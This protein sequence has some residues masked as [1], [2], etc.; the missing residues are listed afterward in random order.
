MYGNLA[1]ERPSMTSRPHVSIIVCTYNR[2]ESLRLTLEAVDAQV[3][4]PDLAWELV[5]VDNNST[6]TT[7]RTVQAFVAGARIPV[8]SIFVSTQG[9]S[10]ARNAGLTQSRGDIVGFTDDDVR[11]A[12]DWVARI[13]TVM[14]DRNADIVGGRILPEW[15][16]PPPPWLA[17]RSSF[18]GALAIV[19]HSEAEQVLNPR[20][21]PSV[22]GA[23]MAFRREVF[24]KVG[25]FDVRRG[26][27]GRKLYRGEEVDLVE[28]A[29]AAGCRAVYDPS[30]VVW[31]RIGPDR[32]RRG[33]LARL[34]FER[35]EG[36][37]LVQTT[38]GH[39]T[40]LGVPLAR[41]RALVQR[42][43]QWLAA[44]VQRRPDTFERW[45]DCCAALGV[46]WGLGKR[47]FRN[48]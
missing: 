29:I 41:Y 31:H 40:L 30:I 28:R 25:M 19:T 36:E 37:A 27:V 33:Y 18:H 23:N 10:H 17:H 21:R 8:R 20:V 35:A 22:W 45:L 12:S 13:A 39:R 3:T 7:R 42:T 38:A 9:L 6:D 26:V 2:A 48:P 11:P 43:T 5:V 32:M 44:A 15:G 1:L 47:H 4:P 14:A 24:E 34:Y 46:V 16:Q